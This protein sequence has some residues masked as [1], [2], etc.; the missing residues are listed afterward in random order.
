[1][2]ATEREMTALRTSAA[3]TEMA[4]AM[5]F[6]LSGEAAFD[7]LDRLCSGDLFLRDG[8]M[9]HT[10][11]LTDEGEPFADLFVCADDRDF[12]LLIE[13]PSQAEIADHFATHLEPGLDLSLS[14]L[15]RSHRILSLNGPWAW[16]VLAE[17]F[18]VEIVGLPY[19]S[20]FH[21]EFGTCFRSGK[22]GEF[23]YDLLVK[24]EEG[25]AIKE[26]LMAKG[27]E[28]DLIEVG[29]PALD[30]CAMENC[31]FSMRSRRPRGLTPLELQLRWRLSHD[32]E[33]VGREALSRRKPTHRLTFFA[34][35]DPIAPGDEILHQGEAIGSVLDAGF[36]SMRGDWIG[37]ALLSLPFAHPTLKAETKG[38]ASIRTLSAPLINNR[39]LY[40]DPRRHS[41]RFAGEIAFPPL[42]LEGRR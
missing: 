39:S 35:D 8:Q 16:E 27:A 6:R 26:A 34:A 37:Q 11:M 42:V 4:H 5:P 13:G 15:C 28:L 41:Y 38:G 23:G 36:S 25:D 24:E 29:L 20:F 22:T 21:A 14:D 9:L 40:L 19:L 32:K 17:W 30:Q 3:L 2:H 18:G 31:F 12:I 7:A 1:M 10:L 33:Y